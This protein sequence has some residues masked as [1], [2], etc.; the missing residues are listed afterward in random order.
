MLRP[1]PPEVNL[2]S[3]GARRAGEQ[4]QLDNMIYSIPSTLQQRESYKLLQSPSRGGFR[5][6]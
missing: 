1:A 6:P 4:Q 5:A 2:A 3:A